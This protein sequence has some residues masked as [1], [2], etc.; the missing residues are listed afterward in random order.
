MIRSDGTF[1]KTKGYCTDVFFDAA[2]EWID[3][4]RKEDKPFFCYVTPNAPHGPL[5]CPP[6]SD[7]PYLAKLEAAGVKDPRQRAEIAKFY[8]MIENIDTNVGRLMQKLD[9]WGLAND[10][11][12]VFTT[13]NGTATGAPVFNAGMRGKKGTAYSGGTRV[14]SFWRWPGTLP[15]GVD[16]PAVTAHIDVLPTLCEFANVAIPAGIAA[17]VEGRS[18][19]PLLRDAKASWPDRPLFTHLGRWDRGKMAE[20]AYRQCRVREGKWSLINVKNSPKTWELYDVAADPGEQNDLAKQH[21]NVVAHLAGEYDRWWRSVQPDLVNEN[22]PVP[23]ANPFKVAYERQFGPPPTAS[24]VS[25]GPHPKQVLH[26][27]KTPQAA[28]DKPA[29]LLFFIHGGGWQGGD[30][31]SGLTGMLPKLLAAG[32]SVVSTEYRFI[33]EAMDADIDPPVQAPLSD[34]ARA[35][36]TVRSRAAEWQIDKTRIAASGGSAGACSSLWL[37]FHDDMAD[38]NRADPVARESTRLL[39][40]AVTGAQTTLDPVQMKEWTPNSRYGGHA[41]GFMKNPENRDT[42]FAE[43]L[44]ARDRLLPVINRYSPY[45]LVTADDPP[46]YLQYGAPP[47]LGQEQKDP[48]HSANFGVKLKVRLDAAGVPC[49]LVYPGA[50]GVQHP[51]VADYL[52]A[53][54]R[55]G[56]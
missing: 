44:A 19:V 26:F 25:Y 11:L 6:G 4:S 30:R 2:L 39:A 22:V 47:A 54:L 43:F 32:V 27:W 52:I 10:T 24:D 17:K 55:G 34:A 41:F 35:L 40:A 49:E 33:K 20:T 1:V 50:A 29:P 7:T 18:L 13:D 56:E 23:A 21:P 31:M 15:V 36:Q 37:A 42:Q 12:V 28:A 48:T 9:E 53:R 8:G 46:V 3:R 5:D 45:A 38:P 16:V 51:S 14:P